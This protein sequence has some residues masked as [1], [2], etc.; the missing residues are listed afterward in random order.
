MNNESKPPIDPRD[1]MRIVAWVMGEASDFEQDELEQLVAE[2]LELAA[3]RDE[4]VNLHRLLA[5]VGSGEAKPE[6]DWR[7]P[8][9]NREHLLA[10]ISGETDIDAAVGKDV[11]RAGW[12]RAIVG[13][14]SLRLVASV[15]AVLL[16]CGFIG[17]S[18]WANSTHKNANDVVVL[19]GGA[20]VQYENGLERDFEKRIRQE[21]ATME[22]SESEEAFNEP[23]DAAIL[24]D[25]HTLKDRSGVVIAPDGGTVALGG[26][27]R[28]LEAPTFGATAKNLESVNGLPGGSTAGE[29]D[30]FKDAEQSLPFGSRIKAEEALIIQDEQGG[31]ARGIAPAKKFSALKSNSKP[32]AV[33]PTTWRVDGQRFGDRLRMPAEDEPEQRGGSAQAGQLSIMSGNEG[34]RDKSLAGDVNQSDGEPRSQ[35]GEEQGELRDGVIGADIRYVPELDQII[36]RGSKRDVGKV[37]EII[38]DIKASDSD[39]RKGFEARKSELQ[40]LD[41]SNERGDSE[42]VD[43][44]LSLSIPSEGRWK[45]ESKK[46]HS[47]FAGKLLDDSILGTM[48][49]RPAATFRAPVSP[50][51]MGEKSA[52]AEAFSTFSLHVSD[53]SFK[54]ALASLSKGQWPDAA[55]IRIEEF[56]NAFNYGDP[57]PCGK[58]RV[59][60][61][62]EQSIHPFF[63]QRNLLRIA[64]RT[65]ATGR[66]NNT[67]LRLTFLL[68][69]SGSMERL[70]RQQTV[71]RAFALLTA[72]LKP[73]DQVTLISFAR[74]PRLLADKVSGN[75]ASQL[76]DL[77]KNLPSEGGTNIEAALNLAF[78]KANE[79]KI[80]SAQ[81]RIILLTDGAVNLGNAN[82]ESLSK[83]VSKMRESGIAFDAAGII[84][85]GLNDE[86]LEALTRKG[87]GRYYLL[88][89]V[90]SAD[91]S[92]V[93]QIAG[94]LR[95]SAKN[96][97]VQVEFNPQRVGHYKLLGFEKHRLNK[98]DFRNDKV[99]AAEMSAAEAGVAL[100]Q[101]EAKPDGEGDIGAVSVRFLDL[102]TGEMVE[103]RWPIPYQS[104]PPRPQQATSTMRVATVAAM[105]AAK[106]QGKPLGEAVDLKSLS[107]LTAGLPA[108][109]R[110]N[111]RIQQLETMVQQARQISG[112]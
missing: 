61:R 70:D 83:M 85:D 37:R 41:S 34:E 50:Q 3:Y 4:V 24:L 22:F 67:P 19:R 5:V 91:E 38:Q 8:R 23:S 86:V 18:Y 87:D 21:E 27:R 32:S 73:F 25:M 72:Q 55:K 28:Q 78:E 94:A 103:N 62:V 51:G 64:M 48:I 109:T 47:A 52:M 65:A 17:V 75:S 92:F 79:Q 81:N 102:A 66:S 97:K 59:A 16:L 60:C 68:D 58:E 98:E 106:L 82:P 33:P 20:S 1:E 84:A 110:A 26:I 46:K 15:A 76:V 35:D 74:Q 107:Q 88:D 89:S 71:R 49:N 104:N 57:L 112:Q 93:R 105:L 54:L 40:K 101:I 108:Q 36:I 69:N 100:Y 2:R 44:I 45:R 13:Q 9:K 39:S 90:D 111:Q 42:V 43:G 29:G 80:E 63:Q 96:V 56:V 12:L 14:R 31:Q 11:L 77:I 95:P 7:L 53:V 30:D 10:V 99:D 6:P